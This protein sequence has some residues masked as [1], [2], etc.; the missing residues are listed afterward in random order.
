MAIL[1]R[2]TNI[3]ESKL[4]EI[5]SPEVA[6]VINTNTIN[7]NTADVEFSNGDTLTDVPTLNY[8]Q[9]DSPCI[10]IYLQNDPNQPFCIPTNNNTSD[11]KKAMGYGGFNVKDNHLYVDIP[12]DME[13]PFTLTNGHLY[14]D[15]TKT[16]VDTSKYTLIN[17]HIFIEED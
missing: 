10:I 9:V 17:N 6:T 7:S 5:Q 1:E 15:T 3:I 12:A 8:P 4:T 14:I 11:I 2:I 13:N 16:S